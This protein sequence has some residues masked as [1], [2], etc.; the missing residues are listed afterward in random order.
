MSGPNNPRWKGGTW[1]NS[2]GYVMV[3]VGKDH[4]MAA[5][6]GLS[7][8]NY[9]KRSRLVCLEAHGPPEDAVMHA[10]HINEDHQDD[11]PENLEWRW[12]S[13]HGKHHLTRERA[14]EIG[15]KGGRA[16]ARLRRR[17]A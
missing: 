7:C 14:R 6:L 2:D 13:D 11:R 12:P 8:R 3:W 9:A 1:I 17:A 15:K 4:P 16:T 5:I 10:H